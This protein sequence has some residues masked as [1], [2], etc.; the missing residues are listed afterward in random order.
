[1]TNDF[2]CK[3]VMPSEVFGQ[4][5]ERNPQQAVGGWTSV[6]PHY[7]IYLLSTPLGQLH[8]MQLISS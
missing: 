7:T 8:H 3:S 2:A 5:A 4:H 1:M 6:L